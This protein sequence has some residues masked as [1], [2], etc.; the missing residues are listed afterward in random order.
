MDSAEFNALTRGLRS[1]A[2]GNPWLQRTGARDG[3][4]RNPRTTGRSGCTP[5]EPYPPGRK[6]TLT[7]K[8]KFANALTNHIPVDRGFSVALFRLFATIWRNATSRFD[9]VARIWA[10]ADLSCHYDSPPCFY[11]V[12]HSVAYG[13]SMVAGTGSGRVVTGSVL[14]I[15]IFRWRFMRTAKL[16]RSSLH[17]VHL[18]DGGP[19]SL[20]VC[21]SCLG[22][23]A[24]NM[25]ARSTT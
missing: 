10:V 19:G 24:S 6:P 7:R 12:P 5:A 25:K 13:R 17:L 8:E 15:V 20:L 22:S 1:I 18:L 23:C 3:C 14:N 16:K 2:P 21:D 9:N 11:A 4:I